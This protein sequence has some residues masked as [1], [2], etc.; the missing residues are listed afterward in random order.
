M[1]NDEGIQGYL[2]EPERYDFPHLCQDSTDSN[3]LSEYKNF[4]VN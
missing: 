4:A 2:Y 1:D 3:D